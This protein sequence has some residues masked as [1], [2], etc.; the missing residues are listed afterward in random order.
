VKT[1]LK[2]R[3]TTWLATLLL[4]T[5]IVACGGGGTS[6]TSPDI[7]SSFNT[8]NEG[9]VM[10][11]DATSPTP[12]YSTTGGVNNSGHIYANDQGASQVYLFQAP[13]KFLGNKEAYY[14]GSL[15]FYLKQQS[16]LSRPFDSDDVILEGA[17][18]KVVYDTP[19]HPGLE[20]SSFTV[21]LRAGAWKVS[22]LSGVAATEAQLRSVLANL[23]ALRIRGEFETGSDTGSLDEVTLSKT[24]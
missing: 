2:S 24:P 13:A 15:S 19:T 18:I 11:G 8:D 5:T 6:T 1:Y 4:L 10:F 21:P 17:G 23:T 12:S 9:W 20:F 3:A 22:S 16:A 14:G 7:V